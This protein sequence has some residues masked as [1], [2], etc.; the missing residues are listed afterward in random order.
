M[1]WSRKKENL[2]NILGTRL[3]SLS[4]TRSKNRNSYLSLDSRIRIPII[5]NTI[6]VTQ[7]STQTLPINFNNNGIK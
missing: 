1:D 6:N 5:V 2:L 4:S 3:R 7:A